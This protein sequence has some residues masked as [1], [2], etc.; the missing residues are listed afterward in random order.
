MGASNTFDSRMSERQAANVRADA[1]GRAGERRMSNNTSN[2]PA[3]DTLARLRAFAQAVLSGYLGGGDEIGDIDGATLQELG[4]R[5]GL[6]EPTTRT[7][8][9]G[10]GCACADVAEGDEWI[11]LKP[12]D[13]LTGAASPAPDALLAAPAPAV[14]ADKGRCFACAKPLKNAEIAD[15]RD[16]QIVFVGSDCF[17]KIRASGQDGYQPPLGGPRLWMQRVTRT[18]AQCGYE[19]TFERPDGDCPRCGFEWSA[20]PVAAPTQETET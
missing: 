20:A 11:C 2:G 9:C 4:A 18:C 17:Q 6:L 16:G 8:I 10:E 7:A 5:H 12:T 14:A 1:R 19:S 13:V 15:T 3:G